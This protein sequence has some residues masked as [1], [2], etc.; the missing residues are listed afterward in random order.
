MKISIEIDEIE[1]EKIINKSISEYLDNHAL[2]GF[3]R[4]EINRVYSVTG[5]RELSEQIRHLSQR[6]TLLEEKMK[7]MKL[8]E[9]D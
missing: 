2:L 9:R 8:G 4:R 7:K 1:L 6:I 5:R 3:M